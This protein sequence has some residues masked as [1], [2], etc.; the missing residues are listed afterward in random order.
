MADMGQ[1]DFIEKTTIDGLYIIERPTFSDDRGFFR[2]VFRLDQLN[3][4]LLTK[5][6]PIQ[7]NHS[8]SKPNV[9]RALHAENWNKLVY[10]ITGKIF[11][12]IADIRPQSSTF[13]KVETF[14]FD[15][16]TEHKVLYISRGL[17]NSI[18]VIGDKPV[19]YMYLVDAYYT[20]GDTTAI[21]WNDADLNIAWPI[22]KPILSQRDMENPTLR[23]KF[24]EKFK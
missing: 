18:C 11:I 8:L 10:P 3:E 14:N 4:R 21:A 24:P 1:S 12:A 22:D 7:W 5:F 16:E 19:N 13:A 6:C 20:G 2:E 15:T 9:I 17:A 23:Q